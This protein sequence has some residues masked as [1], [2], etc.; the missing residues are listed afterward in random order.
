MTGPVMLD[1]VEKRKWFVVS[2]F[3]SWAPS[4]SPNNVKQVHF[5]L[6]TAGATSNSPK[7]L[8]Q[9]QFC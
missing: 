3:R 2:N 6:V 4:D 5:F 7:I 8:A 9:S 1:I